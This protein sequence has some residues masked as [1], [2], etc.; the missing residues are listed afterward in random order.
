LDSGLVAVMRGAGGVVDRV[1]VAGWMDSLDQSGYI[2]RIA[3]D[4]FGQAV[5]KF[6]DGFF[7]SPVTVS[8][9]L[10]IVGV[11]SVSGGD[12]HTEPI[13]VPLATAEKF[14][15][16][17][18][19]NDPTEL[20]ASLQSGGLANPGTGTT[21]R[22][23]PRV[24]LQFGQT[25]PYQ[26]I[27]DSIEARGYRTFS[28]AEQF[29]QISRF[30]VFFDL[31]LALLG[32]IALVTASLGIINTM[33]MAVTERRREIGV[34]KSLGAS[35][36][37]IRVLFLFETGLIGVIGAVSGIGL[38]WLVSR[39]CSAVAQAIMT[40]KG[41]D[42]IDFFTLPWWLIGVAL[43]FGLVVSVAAG[44]YPAARA[45]RVDPMEALRVE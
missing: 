16:G 17:G 40:S 36:I 9:T 41:I 24:T 28:F 21:Y 39:L 18:L 11:L 43:L 35:E 44:A 29:E 4:E 15:A 25:S 30:F 37:D 5:A 14:D 27:K 10:T 34:L 20:L 38:G 1:F 42:P 19:T 33:V 7:N 31:G 32:L 26:P 23:Y 3:R 12:R 2:A 22:Q 6:A 45:S 13:L 8:D